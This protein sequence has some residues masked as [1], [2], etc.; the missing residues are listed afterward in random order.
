MKQLK[1]KLINGPSRSYIGKE[2]TP[3][4]A[5]ISGINC[6]YSNYKKNELEIKVE[7]NNFKSKDKDKSQIITYCYSVIF[8]IISHNNESVKDSINIAVNR[9]IDESKLIHTSKEKWP[10]LDIE[11][12]PNL[13]D[14]SIRDLSDLLEK[15]N[16]L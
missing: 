7:I 15:T 11:C 8:D 3:F 9:A 6:Q 13:V 12:S 10:Q 4:R 14:Y 1:F 16:N 5:S 2:F